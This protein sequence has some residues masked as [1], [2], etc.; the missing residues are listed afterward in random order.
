MKDRAPRLVYIC[1]W[2]PSDFGAV[3][4]YSVLFARELATKGYDVTLAG[5]STLGNSD[6]TE[7]IGLGRYREIK[8]A[9]AS[10]NKSS[11]M[12]RLFW[13]ARTNTRLI[14]HLW[15]HMRAADTILFTGSPPLFLHWITPANLILKKELVYRI[16]DFHPEC[17]IA[18]A[19]GA[20]LFLKLLYRLTLFWRRHVDRFEALGEDQIM[21]LRE[22]GIAEERIRL[23]RDPSPIV[24]SR[25]TSALQRPHGTES[26]L[27]LLYSG[28]W[29]VAHDY[30]TFV[31]GYR[32]HH[33]HGSARFALWLNAVGSAIN[34][35]EKT[36]T[37]DALPYVKGAPV[38]L[39]HLASLLV[40][41]DAHL[42][43]LSDPF[44]G[45][46]LPSKVYGCI[47]SDRPVLF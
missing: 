12:R 18:R 5:L 10:Y 29:G 14:I 30:R 38:P 9:T 45:F 34:S 22:I 2:L 47:A 44:V 11:I 41:P 27:L 46:V 43:T 35:I 26:S 42:I 16:T 6:F 7:R 13:T 3:G 24:I 39:E 25:E 23:K 19:G 17:A 28:N 21:R 8:L 1:D 4:Q 36:L 31:E 15:K 40:T 32:L 20:G 33:R 37:A